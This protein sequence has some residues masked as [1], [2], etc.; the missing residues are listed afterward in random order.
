MFGSLMEYMIGSDVNNYLVVTQYMV[1]CCISQ[2]LSSSR[3]C[4]IHTSSQVSNIVALYFGIR[5]N[6][7]ILFI[8]FSNNIASKENT[9][10]GYGMP[11]YR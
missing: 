9:I 2:K 7:H 1:I 10:A 3:S 8:V 4:F 5:S 11:T 6:N